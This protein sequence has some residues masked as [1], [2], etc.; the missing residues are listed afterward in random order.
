[1][2]RDTNLEKTGDNFRSRMHKKS[3][4]ING[5]IFLNSS[6]NEVFENFKLNIYYIVSPQRVNHFISQNPF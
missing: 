3:L 1:M 2:I 5:K 4:I 6:S